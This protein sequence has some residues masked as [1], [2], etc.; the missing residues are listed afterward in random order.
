MRTLD[1]RCENMRE[2]VSLY[3]LEVGTKKKNVLGQI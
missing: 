3:K 1:S 2:E